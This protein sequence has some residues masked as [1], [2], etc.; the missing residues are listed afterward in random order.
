[1]APAVP[2]L[3]TAVAKQATLGVPVGPFLATIV[4]GASTSASLAGDCGT[5]AFAAGA[6]TPHGT[7]IRCR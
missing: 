5:V 2:S 6:C 4:V 1:M 7:S 3:R